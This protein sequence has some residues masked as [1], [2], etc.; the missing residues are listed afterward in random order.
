MKVG[1]DFGSSYIKVFVLHENGEQ[2][3][4]VF[5]VAKV[6]ALIDYLIALKP[7]RVG[8]VGAGFERIRAQMEPVMKT[9][10]FI[11]FPGA[12]PIDAEVLAQVRGAR[13]QLFLNPLNETGLRFSGDDAVV[14]SI[15]SGVSYTV[16]GTRIVRSLIGNALGGST[17]FW[18][19]FQMLPWGELD[20]VSALADENGQDSTM[21]TADLYVKDLLPATKDLAIGK[22]VASHFGKRNASSTPEQW[23]SVVD[24]LV[25][26][27]VK[28]LMDSQALANAIEQ[29][30]GSRKP[31]Q[32][33]IAIGGTLEYIPCVKERLTAWCALI[34]MRVHIPKHPGHAGA[35]GAA[36]FLD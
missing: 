23:R 26:G 3:Y 18:I 5:D 6:N 10:T 35:I 13:Y 29:A 32:D 12:D 31:I 25:I 4:K 7:K 30:T 14:V 1:V 19:A 24:L 11:P 28:D 21:G 17:L 16:S 2:E 36:L 20:L 15:G 8:Y 22:F 9:L 33:I 34:G 27:I